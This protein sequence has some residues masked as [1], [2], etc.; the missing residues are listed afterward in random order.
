MGKAKLQLC[1]KWAIVERN[2]VKFETRRDGRATHGL[3][4][5]RHFG[6]PTKFLS[7]E[8]QSALLTKQQFLCLKFAFSKGRISIF[9]CRIFFFSAEFAF[10]SAESRRVW[11][12]KPILLHLSLWLHYDASQKSMQ[13]GA[14]KEKRVLFYDMPVLD[15][16]LMIVITRWKIW[17]ILLIRFNSLRGSCSY[18]FEDQFVLHKDFLSRTL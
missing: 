6:E 18:S 2:G 15:I 7:C 4:S 1:G 14:K 16:F 8:S 13:S 17:L 5:N 12:S 11:I 10:L 3:K 9:E